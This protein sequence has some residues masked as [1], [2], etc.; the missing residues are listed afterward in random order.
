[1]TDQDLR[2]LA[3]V[4]LQAH[5]MTHAIRHGFVQLKINDAEFEA[6]MVDN[7]LIDFY[8]LGGN[9]GGQHIPAEDVLRRLAEAG[10]LRDL[11]SAIAELDD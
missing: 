6:M 1:M 5:L 2:A 9:K 3:A 10:S 7:F 8:S 11:Q 4:K